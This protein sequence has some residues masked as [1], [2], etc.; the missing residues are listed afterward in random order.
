MS[1]ALQRLR[2]N[3][4]DQPHLVL[5]LSSAD[6][7]DTDAAALE[8][9]EYVRTLT[10][11]VQELE[12]DDLR[13]WSPGA[14]FRAIG[15]CEN[16]ERVIYKDTST[17]GVRQLD[18]HHRTLSVAFLRSLLQEIQ[19]SSSIFS[20]SL[21]CTFISGSDISSFLDATTSLTEFTLRGVTTESTDRMEDVRD[22]AAALQRNTTIEQLVLASLEGVCL[23]QILHGLGFNS[24]LRYLG[25]FNPVSSDPA[26]TDVPLAI[27]RIL[28]NTKSIQHFRL[29]IVYW[30]RDEQFLPIAQGLI[31]SNVT[32]IGFSY[33][34]FG[35]DGFANQLKSILLS[36]QNLR[37]LA[38]TNC[39]SPRGE[40]YEALNA[41]LLRP[42]SPLRNL[43][44]R[45]AFGGCMIS[46]A[47]LG[48]IEKSNLESL[49]IG[50][51]NP[52]ANL[53]P[54]LTKC[55]RAMKVKELEFDIVPSARNMKQD[56]LEALKNN[57]SL[58]SVKGCVKDEVGFNV[59]ALFNDNDESRL[60][61]YADRNAR[62]AEWVD[63]PATVPRYLWPEAMKLAM[64][65]SEG[66]L[67][68]SLRALSGSN[69]GSTL[70]RRKRK[71]PRYYEPS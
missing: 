32:S 10:L 21:A 1:E 7:D 25:V 6:T 43:K 4:P 33:C 49:D 14:F 46:A 40:I 34:R 37:S 18:N 69:I 20:L 19:R 29:G 16:L 71:R 47:L 24:S 61:D 23:N 5:D 56:L 41:A 58:R 60:R 63:N 35:N 22:L 53:L 55:I 17:M 70:G 51:L 2:A 65:A 36:K 68:C 30:Q 44:L 8:Q 3:D 9:N 67:F 11:G 54:A 52:D 66:S 59:D 50:P 28:E 57:Y 64:E 13:N 38:F 12:M 62:L 45:H 31:R 15:T 39:S 27:Q 48:S 26:D 42:R